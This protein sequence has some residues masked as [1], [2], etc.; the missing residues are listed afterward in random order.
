MVKS[1]HG[2]ELA[3]S[4]VFFSSFLLSIMDNHMA[5]HFEERND[6]WVPPCLRERYAAMRET[7]VAIHTA[8]ERLM[9]IRERLR[10]DKN[11]TR[12]DKNIR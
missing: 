11:I 9:A 10:A 5:E 1:K 7:A 6:R 2:A 3:I 8:R 12:T 4:K